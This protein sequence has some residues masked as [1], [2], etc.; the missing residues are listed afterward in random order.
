MKFHYLLLLLLLSKNTYSQKDLLFRK[1]KVTEETKLICL[2]DH[3]DTLQ[4]RK[5]FTFYCGDQNQVATIFNSFKVGEK[6]H[7]IGEGNEVHIYILKG[8]EIQ[9]IQIMINPK[10]TNVNTD[11]FGEFEYYSFDTSQL[12]NA[13]KYYPIAYKAKWLTF[14]TKKEFDDFITVHRNDTTLLCYEDNTNEYAGSGIG[15][16]TKDKTTTI[17]PEAE[18]FLGKAFKKITSNEEDYSIGLLFDEGNIKSF[19]YHVEC[20][21]TLFDKLENPKFTKGKWRQNK[22]ELLTYWRE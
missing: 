22:F 16:V 21:K 13:H 20:S 8:K 9:P 6:V 17:A 10:Y 18:K 3:L 11:V 5:R 2:T 15:Y 19:K 4:L 7:Q 1:I 12:I 14:D